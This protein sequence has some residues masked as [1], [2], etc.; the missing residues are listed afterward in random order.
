M[1][2]RLVDSSSKWKSIKLSSNLCLVENNFNLSLGA[3]GK[4]ENIKFGIIWNL[5]IKQSK[6]LNEYYC[7]K[8]LSFI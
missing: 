8:M 5:K 2:V 7:W 3:R 1:N 6:V 4:K